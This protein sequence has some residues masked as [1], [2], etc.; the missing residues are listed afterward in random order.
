[1][2]KELDHYESVKVV[3]LKMGKYLSENTN[4][5]SKSHLMNDVNDLRYKTTN[6]VPVYE[7]S[8]FLSRTSDIS[9]SKNL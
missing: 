2:K 9:Y 4:M 3:Q 7:D 5:S 8:V 6:F 1:M